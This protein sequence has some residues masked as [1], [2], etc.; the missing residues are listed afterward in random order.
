MTQ[1]GKTVLITGASGG[2]GQAAVHSF[3]DLGWR[4]FAGVRSLE[5]GE[6]IA[7]AG[8]AVTPVELDLCDE[9]SIAR[10]ARELALQLGP[11]GLDGLVNNAGLSIDGPLELL[12][13]D[14]LCHQFEVNVI[15]QV[16]VTKAFLPMLR[17]ARGRI[18]NIGGAAGRLTLPM[19]GGLSASKAALD[20][21]TTALRM[22]L[23]YQ[24]VSVSYIEPG[25]LQTRFFEKA[26]SR[27]TRDEGNAD[28]QRIYSKAIEVSSNALAKSS[29]SPVEAAVVAIVKAL[30]AR[31]P[32]ARYVVGRQAKLGL[33]VLP[34]LP[35]TLRERL[36]M[37]SLGLRRE[38]FDCATDQPV[39]TAR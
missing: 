13:V 17:L 37:S 16:A 21:L 7:K 33:R 31:R 34:H 23:K 28:A 8:S 4:V 9:A 20:S 3:D 12:A 35:A 19:Y 15:G 39:P 36:L 10:A 2:V 6:T 26:A 11:Q 24:G 30:T 5:R 29:T 25:A 18:V 22:E 1:D 32:A 27:R 14:D 38:T